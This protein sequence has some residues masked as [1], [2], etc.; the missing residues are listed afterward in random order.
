MGGATFIEGAS[1]H[2]SEKEGTVAMKVL[3]HG[4]TVAMKVLLLWRYCCHESTV[5]M[6]VL[7]P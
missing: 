1:R 2:L 5:A 3:L 6:E 7:L 4:G